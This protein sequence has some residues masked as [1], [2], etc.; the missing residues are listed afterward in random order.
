MSEAIR[1][2]LKAIRDSLN[3]PI[4]AVEPIQ[5]DE[6]AIARSIAARYS[7]PTLKDELTITEAQE[8]E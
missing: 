1:D 6:A 3:A 8:T 7:K 5:F 4:E 2:P